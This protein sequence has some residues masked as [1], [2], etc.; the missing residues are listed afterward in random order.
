MIPPPRDSTMAPKVDQLTPLSTASR[1]VDGGGEGVP[2]MVWRVARALYAAEHLMANAGT[3]DDESAELKGYWCASARDAI[4][5]MREPTEAMLEAAGAA[6]L[7]ATIAHEA[8]DKANGPFRRFHRAMI[9]AALGEP[10]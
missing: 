1:G 9:D 8:G 5:A 7:D 3:L 2:T 6:F 4:E 10:R